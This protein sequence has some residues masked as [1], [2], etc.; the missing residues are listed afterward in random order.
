MILSLNCFSEKSTE[1]DL[2][3]RASKII[4]GAQ[5]NETNL[6]LQAI[7]QGI[8]K[9]LGSSEQVEQHKTSETNLKNDQIKL[10]KSSSK[11]IKSNR[12]PKDEKSPTE[13]KNIENKNKS[14]V[15]EPSKERKSKENVK[16]KKKSSLSSSRTNKTENKP[17]KAK[18]NNI[19]SPESI[20]KTSENVSIKEKYSEKG[21]IENTA[22]PTEDILE[23][24]TETLAN[25][26]INDDDRPRTRDIQSGF[27]SKL[28]NNKPVEG[29]NTEDQTGKNDSSRET[30]N[31]LVVEA[32]ENAPVPIVRQVS[33]RPKSARPKS[34]DFKDKHEKHSGNQNK[35]IEGPEI[36]EN[37]GKY[38]Q[39]IRFIRSAVC[40]MQFD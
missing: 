6:L 26:Q 11:E 1:I 9:K 38:L 40:K 8:D 30:A 34:G 7:A 5:P 10:K 2:K 4:A 35:K 18:V 28:G 13:Q 14:K 29:D 32:E 15:R 3:V 20:S 27:L 36:N 22:I 39:V 25:T 12:T 23:T 17:K 33:A 21:D 16:D 24:I 19:E 31:V 37:I